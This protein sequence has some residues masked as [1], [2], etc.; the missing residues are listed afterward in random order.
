MKQL[1]FMMFKNHAQKTSAVKDKQKDTVFCFRK[2]TI[3]DEIKCKRAKIS[4]SGSCRT[5][6]RMIDS[7]VNHCN[8]G[9]G[10][11][12]CQ[13]FLKYNNNLDH[14][15]EFDC[16]NAKKI[17]INMKIGFLDPPNGSL[18][19]TILNASEFSALEIR[20]KTLSHEKKFMY[21]T[22]ELSWHT[23]FLYRLMGYSFNKHGQAEQVLFFQPNIDV[24]DIRL[25]AKNKE[26]TKNKPNINIIFIDSV[27][28]TEFYYAMPKTVAWMRNLATEEKRN[29]LDFK[30]VQSVHHQTFYN[31]HKL[32]NG[33]NKSAR[34]YKRDY[35]IDELKHFFPKMRKSGY[36]TAY[37]RDAC[38]SYYMHGKDSISAKD[39]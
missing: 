23:Y 36:M 29:V 19:W 32:F 14:F 22:C 38:Y 7:D 8:P 9:R 25:S 16:N 21:L 18:K 15:Y 34:V 28:R 4:P 39:A 13:S 5:L 11:E 27:S 20:L 35:E 17:C 12:L 24:S 33:A 10:F 1:V 37:S 6:Q 26:K 31:F 2:R 3:N 30:L